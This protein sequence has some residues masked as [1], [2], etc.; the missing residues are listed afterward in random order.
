MQRGELLFLGTGSSA[1]VPVIGCRCGVCLSSSSYNKR[2][3]P[4]VL[5]TVGKKKILIDAGPDIRT[6]ALRAHID[7]LDGVI[8]THA[9]FDH[10]GG[11]DD[12]RVYYFVNQAPLPCFLSPDTYEEIS[13]RYPYMMVPHHPDRSFPAQFD[14]H[15]ENTEF[16]AVNFAGLKLHLVTYVQLS[17]KVWGF[18]LGNIAYLSDI[19]EFSPRVI[20][21]IKG[22]DTLVISALRHTSSKA[23]LNFE[24]AAAFAYAVGAKQTWLTHLGHD[25]DYETDNRS[26]PSHVG[27]A[28]DGLSLPIVL[29]ESDL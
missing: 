7:H 3:R 18:R 15:I 5:L 1:G 4:S 11:L 6:Q 25:A 9:H 20:D 29:K 8:L 27:L 14:F 22:V 19:K 10:I 21:D 23:H 16:G 12:L 28:Y 13:K 26:L 17:M 2:L 24:E